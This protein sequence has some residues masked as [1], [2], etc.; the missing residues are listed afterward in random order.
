MQG[1]ATSGSSR[2]KLPTGIT[3]RHSRSCASRTGG[4]CNC[5]PSLRVWVYDKTLRNKDGKRVGGKVEKAFSGDGALTEAKKW[6]ASMTTDVN[7]G[8][9]VAPSRRTFR[10]AG[11]AW[12]AG[13]KAEPPTVLN[14]SGRPY[15]PSALRSI[16]RDLRRY[17]YPDVGAH[18]LSEIRRGDLQALVDRLLGRGL[19]AS[20]V[21]GVIVAAR[22]VYRHAVEREDVETNPT[23]GL[24]L[25]AG[26]RPR[27]RAAS[28]TEAAALL[29]A[30]PEADRAL[31]A[32]AFYAGLR[33]GELRALRWEDV[34]LAS[35]VI[36]VRHA[37]DDYVGEI[38]PKS[39]K[40]ARTVPVS[41]LLRDY[42]VELK[43]RTGRSGRDFV[44]GKPDRPFAI[45]G[46]RERAL[47][48]WERENVKRAEAKR[49]PLVPIG[50]HECR[51]TF[52]SL[53]HD[54]GLSLERIGDYV[55]HSSLYMTDRYRHLLEG[56]EQEAARLLDEYLA[57]ADTGSRIE[58]L[59][60]A[61]EDGGE[62]A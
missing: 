29:A 39:A 42:L 19:S 54:A 9:R 6:R 41:A 40:G 4:D 12:L 35:G 26:N 11:E 51:H 2:R 55:G 7:R 61:E 53:L 46:V 38:E 16:E 37:W 34:D 28:A 50:L 36:R 58:Q 1:K 30:L 31:W 59:E 27:D 56:H 33:R 24:R 23:S 14:R 48:A 49:E 10:D 45:W 8:K 57:R 52:V 15:K 20:K 3:E 32:T 25:P 13:A 5:T 47:R 60:A 44:F 22:V 62:L 21:R 17:L 18:R 43:T